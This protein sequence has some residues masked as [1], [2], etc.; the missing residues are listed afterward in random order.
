MRS[1]AQ[2]ARRLGVPRAR[3]A[4]LERRGVRTLRRL[5][6]ATGCA[7]GAGPATTAQGVSVLAGLAAPFGATTSMMLASAAAPSAEGATPARGSAPKD[8]SKRASAPAEGGVKGASAEQPAT[9]LPPPPGSGRDSTPLVVL[10][11]LLVLLGFGLR[12]L[13]ATRT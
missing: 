6:R 7:A 2:V 4:R 10:A 12:A 8:D 11:G 13:R 3:V 5:D 9:V 1:R